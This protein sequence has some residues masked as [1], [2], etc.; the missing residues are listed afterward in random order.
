MDNQQ[1]NWSYHLYGLHLISNR[2]IP[3]LIPL[4]TSHPVDIHVDIY[5]FRADKIT[6]GAK[7][8]I[9]TSNGRTKH[10][11]PF[12]TVWKQAGNNDAYVQ[13]CYN[14][15]QGHAIF[16][17]NSYGSIIRV[18][19]TDNVPFDD[20]VAYLLGPVIGCVLR[21]RGFTCLHAGVVAFG[22]TAIAIIGPKGSG[23]TTLTAF[24]SFYGHSVLADDIAL[25]IETGERF[26]IVPGYP[27][28][29]LCPESLALFPALSVDKLPRVLSIIEK[30]YLDLSLDTAASQW[31]FQ[32]KHLPLSAVYVLGTRE[33]GKEPSIKPIHL[34][35]GIAILATHAYPDYF[36]DRKMRSCDFEVLGRLCASVPLRL[37]SSP[38]SL[39]NLPRL[40]EIML[41]DFF[42]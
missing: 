2:E 40:Y 28:L 27:R 13:L 22:E 38:D 5:S 23:K 1:F 32:Q 14:N 39:D 17:I 15:G 7:S 16:V 11:D 26:Y 18:G 41:N 24:L 36:L 25:L 30:R 4:S 29:R 42:N 9:Y 8:I 20:I 31:R 33:Y 12:L 37:V 19:C 6:S 10:G 21:L 34:S 3:G 35:A